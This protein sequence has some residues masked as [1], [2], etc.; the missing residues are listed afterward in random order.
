MGL[1]VQVNMVQA[2]CCK[3]V[4]RQPAVANEGERE[5]EPCSAGC[6]VST[7]PS[8]AGPFGTAPS[9]PAA[10]SKKAK[11]PPS[12]IPSVACVCVP[13]VRVRATYESLPI[14]ALVPSYEHPSLLLLQPQSPPI[15]ALLYEP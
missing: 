1:L 8:W 15:R 6:G 14:G 13:C 11:T 3:L 12:P 5:R 7:C 2:Y 10:V 4:W 9:L